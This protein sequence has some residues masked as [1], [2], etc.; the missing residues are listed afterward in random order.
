MPFEDGAF[1]GLPRRHDPRVFAVR[2]LLTPRSYW[3]VA[4]IVAVMVLSAMAVL[5]LL[6]FPWSTVVSVPLVPALG[7]A[8]GLAEKVH[9]ARTGG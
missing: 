6:R 5:V 3:H 1:V 9:R 8:L 2:S 7:S 4:G